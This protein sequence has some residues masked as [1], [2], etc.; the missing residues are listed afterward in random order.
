MQLRKIN[1]INEGSFYVS[2]LYYNV[3][4]I[5]HKVHFF[6]VLG[7]VFLFRFVSCDIHVDLVILLGA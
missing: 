2:T 1:V 5:T 4:Y 3:L 7:A 6:I